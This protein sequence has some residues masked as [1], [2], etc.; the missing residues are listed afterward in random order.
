LDGEPKAGSDKEE[1]T[2]C[3]YDQKIAAAVRTISKR[4]SVNL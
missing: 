1:K 3:G 2:Q 4:S